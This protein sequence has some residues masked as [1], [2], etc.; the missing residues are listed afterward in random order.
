MKKSHLI[1]FVVIVVLVIAGA[2]AVAPPAEA[3]CC[4]GPGGG[5]YLMRFSYDDPEGC[6]GDPYDCRVLIVTPPSS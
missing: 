6:S 2:V 4:G 1:G 5:G 3:E